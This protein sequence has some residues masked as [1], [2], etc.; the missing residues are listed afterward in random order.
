M[1][2]V[3]LSGVSASLPQKKKLKPILNDISF[4]VQS[5]KCLAVLGASGHGKTTL[6]RVIAGFVPI[7]EGSIELFG[8]LANS[9][10][11]ERRGLSML[12]QDPVLFEDLSVL[13]NA[14]IGLKEMKHKDTRLSRIHELIIKFKL[15][16]CF[17]RPVSKLSGGERQRAALV[18][19]FANAK[20]IILLDEPL[21]SALDL[22]LRWSLMKSI[23]EF[24]VSE[25]KT[26]IFVTH[27]FDEAAYLADDIIVLVNGTASEKMNPLEAYQS[28]PNQQV[29]RILG[30][31]N[32]FDATMFLDSNQ[33]EIMCPISISDNTSLVN[34]P[35]A[36]VVLF[37]P[38]AVR[39][40]SG[41]SF[42]V[43][44]ITFL[45][46][47]LRVALIPTNT[48]S[49]L[50]IEVAIS[51]ENRISIGDQVGLE[52]KSEEICFFDAAGRRINEF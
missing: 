12:F 7:T 39:I 4:D 10:L 33:R 21:K 26:C 11:P 22:D 48:Q 31:T 41:N 42:L 3:I 50:M 5:E 36:N 1:R 46:E 44:S 8:K 19:T 51:K 29:A 25:K 40:I 9:I 23:K 45:G 24:L 20:K 13:K 27:R 43:Q 18:R 47:A 52:V 30:P 28:P 49:N 15:E 37:R 16:N 34:V 17:D 32:E 2:D 38:N 6:L 14:M 35:D